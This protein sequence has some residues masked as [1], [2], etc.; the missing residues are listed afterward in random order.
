MATNEHAAT[1]R[2]PGRKLPGRAVLLG[3]V[4]FAA[5]FLDFESSSLSSYRTQGDD[6]QF[7][8]KHQQVGTETVTQTMHTGAEEELGRMQHNQLH[9]QWGDYTRR[10]NVTEETSSGPEEIVINDEQLKLDEQPAPN[11]NANTNATTEGPESPR[12]FLNVSIEEIVIEA[13]NS[14]ESDHQNTTAVH[15]H[16]SS[17]NTGTNFTTTKATMHTKEEEITIESSDQCFPHNTKAWLNGNRLSNA[18]YNLTDDFVYRQILIQNPLYAD[19]F[20]HMSSQTICHKDSKF[21]NPSV[22][23]DV[24]NEQL[25]QE[26][27]FRLLYMAIHHHHHAPAFPEAKA[28]L[29]CARE[30]NI[31]KMDY[32]CPSSKFL[33]SNV[34]GAGLGASVRIGAVNSLLMGIATDR[35]AVFVND[36]Q[37]GAPFLELPLLLASCP[38]RDIQ[39]FYLPS[40]PCTITAEDLR[41]ATV[42]PEVDARDLRRQGI[43]DKPEY[44]NAT[45]LVVEPKINP[46]KKWS[47]QVKIQNRLYDIAMNL[48][49][50]IRESAP[51]EQVQVL[52]AA[53][54]RI[55][56]DNATIGGYGAN[57]E[58]TAEYT[59]GNRYTKTAHA[60]LMYLLRPNLNYQRLSD[61]MVAS[62][63]PD[64]IDRSLSIGLPI[65]GSDKCDTE[66][67]CYGFDTYMKLARR[68]WDENLH[69]PEGKKGDIFLTTEDQT[70]MNARN[71]YESN[72][73][74][75]Y[76]FI[77][78]DKDVLQ[79]SGKPQHFKDR[80]DSIMLSS[81][82]SM[83]LQLQS[84]FAVGNCCSNFHL[85]LFDLIHEGCG[86]VPDSQPM[87]LQEHPDPQ[88]H[89]CCRWTK[90]EECDRVRAAKVEGQRKQE[91]VKKKSSQ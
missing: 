1:S 34:A 2:K 82:V 13:A 20:S 89:L 72:E 58:S 62:I 3:L 23:W 11:A 43:L 27:E 38:R 85:M 74:F 60:A 86:A 59:Y 84:K 48:I 39:C 80:A 37:G 78:N 61:E 7:D 6:T 35:I 8:A 68:M 54:A 41:K 47:I 73:S 50:G 9:Q 42:L 18:D 26:W 52:E 64:D 40:T 24:N 71:E 25:I 57:N 65:R 46:P 28:R 22:E 29:G 14:T 79:S 15:A 77:V 55:K 91:A 4:A 75:P 67:S 44:L 76:R 12:A 87:C 70:I 31:S 33:V 51:P 5:I 83:K 63:V 17:N 81:I 21:R 69:G 56:L 16:A 30:L 88:F 32:E 36:F 90:S 49:D 53:A 10:V 45:I 66:S 19:V